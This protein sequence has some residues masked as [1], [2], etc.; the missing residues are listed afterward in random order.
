[1]QI[2]SEVIEGEG[3]NFDVEQR[4]EVV[5]RGV[6][7]LVRRLLEALGV[8]TFRVVVIEFVASEHTPRNLLIAG[9]RRATPDATART[10]AREEIRLLK[11]YFGIGRQALDDLLSE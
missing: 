3:A 11:T 7:N 6:E 1:V 4:A 5:G 8:Q 2:V 9:V 10:R